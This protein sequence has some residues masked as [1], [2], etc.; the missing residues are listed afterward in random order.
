M[1]QRHQPRQG[2]RRQRGLSLLVVTL[3]M[4]ALGLLTVSSYVNSWTQF[5]L[6]G[7]L[8]A[9]ELAFSRA[10]AA[11]ASAEAWLNAGSN[12]QSSAFDSY[13]VNHLYPIGQFTLSGYSAAGMTWSDANSLVSGNA[14]YLIEQLGRGVRQ[15]G[16]A[17]STGPSATSCRAVNLFRVMARGEGNAA[18]SR[19]IEVTTAVSA[20]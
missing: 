18:A 3:L 9:S 6:S 20:C 13:S 5:R 14:R 17:L 12:A 1:I 4:L 10:E 19:I 8:Q 11:I 15:P 7:N 2:L 16:D